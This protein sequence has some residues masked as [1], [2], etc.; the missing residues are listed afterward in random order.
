MIE[1]LSWPSGMMW[2]FISCKRVLSNIFSS[3]SGVQLSP[4]PKV[5]V[6]AGE[7]DTLMGVALMRRMAE[8]YASAAGTTLQLDSK[9]SDST[10]DTSV[11]SLHVTPKSGHNLMKD[12]YWEDS[13]ER[14]VK[15]LDEVE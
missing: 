9:K 13:A 14:I 12:L 6:V 10:D 11:V 2:P 15:F 4:K 5:L 7:K 8:R 1:S 3:V